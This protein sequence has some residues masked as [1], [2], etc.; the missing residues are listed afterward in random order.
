MGWPWPHLAYHSQR[1]RPFSCRKH[2]L[3]VICPGF[4]SFLC[5][6]GRPIGSYPASA[7]F[8]ARK[9]NGSCHTPLLSLLAMASVKTRLD[10]CQPLLGGLFLRHRDFG[11][12]LGYRRYSVRERAHSMDRTCVPPSFRTMSTN[13]TTL[14]L[15]TR[16]CSFCSRSSTRDRATDQHRWAE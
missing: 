11:V 7:L 14:M 5:A 9:D 6:T 10:S 13:L 8:S 15:W 16:G 2:H 1:Q 12:F 4:S 3:C